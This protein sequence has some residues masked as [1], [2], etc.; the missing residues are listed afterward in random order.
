MDE[1]MQKH[2]RFVC[3]HYFRSVPHSLSLPLLVLHDFLFGR[4]P[5]HLLTIYRDQKTLHFVCRFEGDSIFSKFQALTQTKINNILITLFNSFAHKDIHKVSLYQY[6]DLEFILI[7][8]LCL[9][10][11]TFSQYDIK[12]HVNSQL[13]AQEMTW[14]V[15]GFLI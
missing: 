7:C 14:Y 4:N 15:C 10:C 13:L 12:H 11:D 6:H 3:Q 5:A 8:D 9:F 2:L 1:I